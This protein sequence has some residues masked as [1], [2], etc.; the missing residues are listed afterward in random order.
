MVL[1]SF[2][3]G[4][5]KCRVKITKFLII[6]KQKRGQQR[7]LLVISRT[8]FRKIHMGIIGEIMRKSRQNWMDTIYI[9]FTS[10]PFI[11]FWISGGI[12]ESA[13][14]FQGFIGIISIAV[15]SFR[16]IPQGISTI[17]VSVNWYTDRGVV[18]R[19]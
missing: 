12:I 11:R 7:P 9:F 4:V 1:L 2:A 3:K 17:H 8:V 18:R 5:S 13:C 15:F 16:S 10:W 19:V 6:Q 14:I